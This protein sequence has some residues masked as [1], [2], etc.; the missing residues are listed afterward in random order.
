M[1]AATVATAAAADADND[2]RR[3]RLLLRG[4]RCCNSSQSL[5]GNSSTCTV[6]VLYTGLLLL[7]NCDVMSHFGG[8]SLT[9]VGLDL[10]MS[11]SEPFV[12]GQYRSKVMPHTYAYA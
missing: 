12:N 5:R 4:T 11:T 9:L 1:A 10:I 6:Q 8:Y 3:R 2:R 7:W